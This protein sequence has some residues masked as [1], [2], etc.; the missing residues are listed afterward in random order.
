MADARAQVLPLVSIGGGECDENTHDWY[1][2]FSHMGV[3]DRDTL[4]AQRVRTLGWIGM[5]GCV[6]FL[7]WRWKQSEKGKV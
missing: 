4:I 7:V 6:L 3:L 2:I 5:I 1:N